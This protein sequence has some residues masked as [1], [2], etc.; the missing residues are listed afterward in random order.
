M[1]KKYFIFLLVL[2]ALNLN[3]ISSQALKNQII[4]KVDNN[5]ITDYELKKGLS[6]IDDLKERIQIQQQ[7]KP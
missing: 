1:V 4:V 7:L 2:I 6:Y 3:F 5:I